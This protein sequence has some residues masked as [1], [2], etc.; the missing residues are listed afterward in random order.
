[1]CYILEFTWNGVCLRSARQ[2]KMAAAVRLDLFTKITLTI[3][4]GCV[5]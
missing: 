4:L 5:L 2:N 1:M 3:Q